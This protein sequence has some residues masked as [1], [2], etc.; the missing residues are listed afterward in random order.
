MQQ[1]LRYA[2]LRLNAVR[3]GVANTERKRDLVSIKFQQ[4]APINPA[5]LATFVS[6]HRG[7]QFLPDGTLKFFVRGQGPQE[8]LHLL[9]SLLEELSEQ[10]VPAA[11]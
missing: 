9:Q 4:D 11:T 1:L 7:S 8:L 2:A 6:A 10:V 5:K 3:A